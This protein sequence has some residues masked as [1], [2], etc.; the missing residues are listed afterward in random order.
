MVLFQGL[1]LYR[2][3]KEIYKKLVKI[4]VKER[5][6]PKQSIKEYQETIYCNIILARLILE[7]YIKVKNIKVN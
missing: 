1:G 4:I 5:K 6:E 2:E 3:G 7:R